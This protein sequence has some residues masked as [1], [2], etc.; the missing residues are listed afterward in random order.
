M[1]VF[2]ELDTEEK[3]YLLT[4][5]AQLVGGKKQV[6]ITQKLDSGDGTVESIEAGGDAMASALYKSLGTARLGC[7]MMS[8]RRSTGS[9]GLRFS[10]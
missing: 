6:K 4:A 8:R 10:S 9:L 5:S 3:G 1:F 2:G 7:I